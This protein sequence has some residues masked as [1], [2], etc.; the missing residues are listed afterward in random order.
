MLR[1]TG[2]LD[3]PNSAVVAHGARHPR[4]ADWQ[5]SRPSSSG[6]AGARG[7]AGAW[8]APG[9]GPAA[10]GW[11]VSPTTSS[12]CRHRDP[13]GRAGAG[14]RRPGA[15]GGCRVPGPTG[16]GHPRSPCVGVLGLRG[17]RQRLQLHGR[18]QRHLR[19]STAAVAGVWFAW[20]G[21]DHVLARGR[22]SRGGPRRG[23]LSASCRGTP[24]SR[25]SSSATWAATA[26]GGAGG[27][28]RVWAWAAGVPALLAVAPLLVYLADTGWVLVKRAMAGE[29]L[30]APHRSTSTSG[31][32]TSGLASSGR[33]GLRALASPASS[34]SSSPALY[35]DTPRPRSLSPWLLVL[36]VYLLTAAARQPPTS[37]DAVAS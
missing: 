14:S 3:V 25:E 17:L 36:R 5:C 6:V 23:R 21:H 12:S 37:A 33:S 18:H 13:A 8:P 26:I 7:E 24:A 4:A 22:G 32:S 16:G 30:M 27:R 9:A 10:R 11:W 19:R 2:W 20:I 1:R 28:C 29:R 31:S 15:L 34:A 35:D